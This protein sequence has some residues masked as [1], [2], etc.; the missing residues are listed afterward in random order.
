[1]WRYVGLRNLKSFP[2][3]APWRVSAPDRRSEREGRRRRKKKLRDHLAA[4][5][6]DNSGYQRG[7]CNIN[8]CAARI[9]V[10]RVR[11]IF[12]RSIGPPPTSVFFSSPALRP[13]PAGTPP[14]PG[15]RPAEHV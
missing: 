12:R 15:K 13:E 5:E 2:T 10:I 7:P 1:M 6:A 14:A 11:S 3:N 8:I 4:A 9:N